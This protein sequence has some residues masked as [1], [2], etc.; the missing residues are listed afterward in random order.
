VP[1]Q[2]MMRA[3]MQVCVLPNHQGHG[4]IQVVGEGLS[5]D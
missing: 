1:L 3:C 2:H 5:V 4:L